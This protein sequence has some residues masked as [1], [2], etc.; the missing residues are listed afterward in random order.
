LEL[1][2]PF[3]T[4]F[5]QKKK[6]KIKVLKKITIIK[7]ID[8]HREFSEYTIQLWSLTRPWKKNENKIETY[9]PPKH[10]LIE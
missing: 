3:A 7:V 6:K 8:C 2:S 1:I 5:E 9:K 10:N 4:I